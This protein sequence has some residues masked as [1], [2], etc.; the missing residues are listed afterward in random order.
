M[1][2]TYLYM[3]VDAYVYTYVPVFATQIVSVFFFLQT[4][5]PRIERF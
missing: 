5:F 3:H 4:Q 2:Y 1:K